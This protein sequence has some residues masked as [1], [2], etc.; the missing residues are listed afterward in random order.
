MNA[1][2][3]KKTT[4]TTTD[5]ETGRR[6]LVACPQIYSHIVPNAICAHPLRMLRPRS[7]NES[8]SNEIEFIIIS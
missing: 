6:L 5:K 2:V 7:G 3:G 8:L 1:V 4:E